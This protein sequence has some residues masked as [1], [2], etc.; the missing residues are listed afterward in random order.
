MAGRRKRKLHWKWIPVKWLK[1]KV[2][3]KAKP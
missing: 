2:K 1:E 3:K